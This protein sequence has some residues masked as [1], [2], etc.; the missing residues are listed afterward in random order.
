MTA[1]DAAHTTAGIQCLAWGVPD[2]LQPL[3]NCWS[4]VSDCRCDGVKC[5]DTV[6]VAA[7]LMPPRG[8]SVPSSPV[9]RSLTMQAC[10]SAVLVATPY[11]TCCWS[12]DSLRA[13]NTPP[14][15]GK[16]L[17]HVLHWHGIPAGNPPF[18]FRSCQLI[19]RTPPGACASAVT[20]VHS[21]CR[22]VVRPGACARSARIRSSLTTTCSGWS[23]QLL[24]TRV[25]VCEPA[26]VKVVRY[27]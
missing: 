2:L 9:C 8:Q 23:G 21:P 22:S 3:A 14:A 25:T 20:A 26:G 1:P 6:R 24:L 15:R 10:C 18:H 4:Q 17:S 12:R 16:R 27:R 13:V 7:C 11:A 5:Q 19:K